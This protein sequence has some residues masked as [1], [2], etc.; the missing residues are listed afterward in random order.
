MKTQ[1]KLIEAI[2]ACGARVPQARLRRIVELFAT[3]LGE[4][5]SRRGAGAGVLRQVSP[6]AGRPAVQ[7][8]VFEP[9]LT[10]SVWRDWGG[11]DPMSDEEVLDRLRAGVES[12]EYV[13]WRVLTIHQEVLGRDEVSLA[14]LKAAEGRPPEGGP[15]RRLISP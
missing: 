4:V 6:T 2:Q 10:H 11:E 1:T 3:W 8:L 15:G 12:G 7:V 5:E 14:R 9:Q 13:G